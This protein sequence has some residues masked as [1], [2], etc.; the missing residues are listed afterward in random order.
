MSA[1]AEE[2]LLERIRGHQYWYHSFD[3]GGGERIVG[4]TES[5]HGIP[6]TGLW[7]R[8]FRYYNLPESLEG[9]SVLDVGGWDGALSFE[10]ER[11]G[12]SRVVLTNLGNVA[13]SDFALAGRGTR[14]QR[15]RRQVDAGRPYWFEDGFTSAGALLMREWYGSNV[16]LVL[17]SVYDLDELLD[18]QFDLV[19]CCGLLYHLRDPILALQVCRRLARR[20]IIVESLCRPAKL[21]RRLP[22]RLER[23]LLARFLPSPGVEYWGNRDDGANWWRFSVEALEQMLEDADFHEVALEEH[24]GQRCVL[25]G[26]VRA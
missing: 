16:E 10:C 6:E 15:V 11:R 24:V 17:G 13:D 25:S 20:Q 22:V 9:W 18:E 26:V 19:L 12:A 23:M 1:E 3:L 21:T 7:T 2:R 5:Q 4:A 8:G 14:E